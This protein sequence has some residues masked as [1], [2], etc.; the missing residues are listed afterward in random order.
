MVILQVLCAC[1]FL[2]NVDAGT[3]SAW[4]ANWG[5]C[6]VTCG[7]GKQTK[8]RTC[9]VE[10][11]DGSDTKERNCMNVDCPLEIDY[12]YMGCWKTSGSVVTLENTGN[13]YVD[14]NDPARGCARAAYSVGKDYFALKDNGECYAASSQADYEA[15]GPGGSCRYGK[16]TSSAFDVYKINPWVCPDGS[17]YAGFCEIPR[18]RTPIPKGVCTTAHFCHEVGGT[19]TQ[20]VAICCTKNFCKDHC[21][22]KIIERDC[23]CDTACVDFGDCCDDFMDDCSGKDRCSAV[24]DPHYTSFDNKY[25]HYQGKC[26]YIMLS[27]KCPFESMPLEIIVKNRDWPWVGSTVTT[28]KEVHVMVDGIDILMKQGKQLAIDGTITAAPVDP[29]PTISVTIAGIY[30]VVRTGYGITVYFDGQYSLQVDASNALKSKLCGLCGNFNGNINDDFMKP[31]GTQAPNVVAFGD[32]W[33]APNPDCNPALRSVDEVMPR[34][35]NDEAVDLCNELFNTGNIPQCH[36]VVDKTNHQVSCEMDIGFSL[37]DTTEGCAII[38]DYVKLCIL[39]GVDIGDW[40]SGTQCEIDCPIDGMSYT[41]CGPLCPATCLDPH[42]LGS[43][44]EQ[45]IEG[46]F[47]AAGFVLDE[48]GV[49]IEESECGCYYLNTLYR[50][51]EEMPNEKSCCCNVTDKICVGPRYFEVNT[52][53]V[54]WLTA[55]DTCENRGGMLAKIDTKSVDTQIRR[56]ISEY[57]FDLSV[58]NGFWFG[59]ND[60]DNEGTFVWTDGTALVDGDFTRWAR[61]QPNNNVAKNPLGQDCVQLWKKKAFKWDDNNCN[62][63]AGFVC[64]YSFATACP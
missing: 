48:G 12:D 15:G 13:A 50:L 46:C 10:P 41:P 39:E 25:Y 64:E 49:C 47:C 31:D 53:K 2:V 1:A 63:A 11:C 3:W 21:G 16:G 59:L 4:S 35:T 36:T 32:S 56:Y 19:T 62:E 29:S 38:A 26:E 45:C 33:I 34:Q 24:G 61:R 28:T 58:A 20:P 60:I 57:E 7:T 6:P 55:K 52:E 22:E 30:L 42:P 54:D 5:D 14:A 44:T 27:S 9:D 18:V 23:W 43:C 51:H 17:D 8:T 37:P 40:R